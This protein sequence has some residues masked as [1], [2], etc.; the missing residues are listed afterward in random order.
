MDPSQ[1]QIRVGEP[2]RRKKN[3]Q[4]ARNKEQKEGS[5]VLNPIAH[6]KTDNNAFIY[7]IPKCT[8]HIT[9]TKH[10]NTAPAGPSPA[11][12]YMRRLM[13]F[14][15]RWM[16][17]ASCSGLPPGALAAAPAGRPLRNASNS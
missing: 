6:T 16:R 3:S 1:G 8:T 15:S 17:P 10:L 14:S 4:K 2:P 5:A 12:G 13:S 11:G 9:K 7:D